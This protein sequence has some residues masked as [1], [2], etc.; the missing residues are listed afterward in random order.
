MMSVVWNDGLDWKDLGE[1]SEGPARRATNAL[2]GAGGY[3]CNFPSG[4][5]VL[6]C[7]YEQL[8]KFKILDHKGQCPVGSTW[9]EDWFFAF[10][11]KGFWAGTEVDGPCTMAAAMHCDEGI[12]VERFWL[13]HRIDAAAAPALVDGDGSEWD[14]TQ[15]LFLSS[16]EGDETLFRARQESLPFGRNGIHRQSPRPSSESSSCRL[17]FKKIRHSQ[18]RFGHRQ[19]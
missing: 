1:N 7:T 16:G 9:S 4:E 2:R 13:N 12:Q 10:P 3:V 18:H 8:L 5:V 15:A 11:G 14:G 6:S 17:R 19:G